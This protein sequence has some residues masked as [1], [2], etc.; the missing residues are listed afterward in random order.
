MK[1]PKGRI[2][3]R[4]EIISRYRALFDECSLSFWLLCFCDWGLVVLDLKL[5]ELGRR[6]VRG[7]WYW[8]RLW[9]SLVASADSPSFLDAIHHFF[10]LEALFASDLPPDPSRWPLATR[11]S[12][13]WPW[14]WW[15]HQ[16]LLD[17]S[18]AS[19]A[20]GSTIQGCSANCSALPSFSRWLWPSD[21][22]F[23]C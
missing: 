21:I 16:M 10:D 6:V 5:V 8:K 17:Y 4:L 7:F 13:S 2:Y 20:C 3:G 22:L 19:G 15:C 9:T 18:E 1:L 23:C 12:C 11:N 14:T